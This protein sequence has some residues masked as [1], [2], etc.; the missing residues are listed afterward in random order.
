MIENPW[1]NGFFI[2]IAFIK[3]KNW[4]ILFRNGMKAIYSEVPENG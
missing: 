1:N 3:C 2:Q 4:H